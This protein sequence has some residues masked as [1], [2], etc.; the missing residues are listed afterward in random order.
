MEH[1]HN[2][3]QAKDL[4]SEQLEKITDNTEEHEHSANDGHDHGVE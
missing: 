4:Q 2:V 3:E 1:N